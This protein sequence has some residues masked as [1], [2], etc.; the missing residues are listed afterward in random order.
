MSS[1]QLNAPEQNGAPPPTPPSTTVRRPAKFAP[2]IDVPEIIALKFAQGKPVTSQITG[3]S[4]VLL[5]LTD[6]RPWYVSTFIADRL[7]E[8]GI[9][10]REQI[11]VTKVGRGPNDWAI[12]PLEAHPG[13]GSALSAAPA[14]IAQTPQQVP[15]PEP[16]QTR[17]LTGAAL[18]MMSAMCAAVDAIVETH[19]YATRHGIGLT[20]SEES[21]RC[22]GLSIYI[23]ACREAVR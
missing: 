13:E 9:E 23:S 21:V 5:T 6:N 11:E 16:D 15:P 19:A 3:E 1:Q 2:A 4:Q 20:F 14:A 17:K 8:A 7:R 22:I 10:A 12:V 18:C